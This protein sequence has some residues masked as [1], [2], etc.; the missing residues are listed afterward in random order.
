[1]STGY[2]INTTTTTTTIDDIFVSSTTPSYIITNYSYKPNNVVTDIG[3]IFKPLSTKQYSSPTGYR[4][5]NFN[6][7][8][9]LGSPSMQ[10]QSIACSTNSQYI[11]AVGYARGYIYVSINYGLTWTTISSIGITLFFKSISCTNDGSIVVAVAYGNNIY[12]SK[13]YGQ[14]WADKTSVSLGVKNWYCV[15]VSGT[16]GQYMV[17]SIYQ[18]LIYYSDDTG[19]T[20]ATINSNNYLC[21]SITL[22]ANGQSMSIATSSSTTSDYIYIG[23]YPFTTLT[24][25]GTNDFW[26]SITSSSD[27]TIQYACT[28]GSTG[29]IYKSTNSGSTWGK[30]KSFPNS[31][32]ITTNSSGTYVYVISSSVSYILINKNSESDWTESGSVLNL[33]W[34]VVKISPDNTKLIGGPGTKNIYMLN[35][36]ENPTYISDITEMFEAK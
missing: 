22:S 14:T 29:G 28:S 18:N 25:V 19:D 9:K 11:Y 7:T 21:N 1:M 27:N 20:W 2:K 8:I 13:D 26:I 32:M 36:I 10:Y 6:W 34:E 24:S 23:S 33:S 16:S 12:V 3:A 4:F 15:A 5:P 30:I 31:K 35:I 17:A